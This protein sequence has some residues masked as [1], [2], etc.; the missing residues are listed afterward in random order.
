MPYSLV[1]SIVVLLTL[2]FFAGV[3]S[4]GKLTIRYCVYKVVRLL[5]AVFTIVYAGFTGWQLYVAAQT[6]GELSDEVKLLL[7]G[8]FIFWVLAPPAWFFLEY[9]AFDNKCITHLH[10]T[11][12]DD[13]V[14][15]AELKRIKNYGD[16]ASKIWA[17]VV[18]LFGALVV[19]HG[20]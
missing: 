9:F 15:E 2:L 3:T 16:Y 8:F 7:I 19:L 12:K 5:V 14:R 11:K 17:A 1:I 10:R 4:T 18:A 20:R 6:H 13:E